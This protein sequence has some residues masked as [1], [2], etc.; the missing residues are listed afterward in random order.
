MSFYF[1]ICSFDVTCEFAFFSLLFIGVPR[2]SNCVGLTVPTSQV[3]GLKGCATTPGLHFLFLKIEHLFQLQI[4]RV[5]NLGPWH[6]QPGKE[7]SQ[8]TF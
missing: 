7:L 6:R 3:L 5:E 4:F 2:Q 8:I 1:F